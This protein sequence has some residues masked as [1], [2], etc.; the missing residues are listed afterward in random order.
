ML[1]SFSK[2]I[3]QVLQVSDIFTYQLQQIT[4]TRE[5]ILQLKIHSFTSNEQFQVKTDDNMC[6]EQY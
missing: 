5:S 1:L 2:E 6:I 4:K 3:S